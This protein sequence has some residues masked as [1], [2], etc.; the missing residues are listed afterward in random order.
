ME[1]YIKNYI[2]NSI[3]AKEQILSD[4]DLLS[5]IEKT[6]N[7]IVEAYNSGK[8]VLT[9]GNG[10][11]AGDAQHI[12]AELVSKFMLD[13]PALNAIAL[14][15][16]SSILTAV[17]N[18]Y[19]AE[20]IFSRQIQAYGNSGDIFIAIS[21][22]GNSLNIINAIKEAKNRGMVVIGL[23]GS[24][25]SKMDNLCD[26]LLRVPSEQTPII[27]ESHIMMGHIICAL[28]EKELFV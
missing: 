5:L 3:L 10:G 12:A 11:S 16:N 13:R 28:V 25:K 24:K 1:N 22:S 17:G 20:Y 21:T 18:D 27:Q 9:A 6:A 19:S 7:L 2:K 15:T 26:I 23:V 14:T 8:K 4:A